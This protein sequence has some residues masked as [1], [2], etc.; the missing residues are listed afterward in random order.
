M[1]GLIRT[2]VESCEAT[3]APLP[4]TKCGLSHSG[5]CTSD[6]SRQQ[7][8]KWNGVNSWMVRYVV[9]HSHGLIHTA[10]QAR[11]VITSL[12]EYA[13]SLCSVTSRDTRRVSRAPFPRPTRS[14]GNVLSNNTRRNLAWNNTS[15][16]QTSYREPTC[17]L[18]ADIRSRS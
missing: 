18:R 15:A 3:V 8:T 16:Q 5:D 7:Q 9:F 12:V 11:A 6:T 10:I 4:W 13:L 2:A 1:D 14:A 17:S